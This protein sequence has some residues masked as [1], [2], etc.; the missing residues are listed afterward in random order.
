MSEQELKDV[1]RL[2]VST[3]KRLCYEDP[4]NDMY[5]SICFGRL[6]NRV[7][8][9]GRVGVGDQGDVGFARGRGV[10][11]DGVEASQSGR[12]LGQARR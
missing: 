10:G 6:S 1:S 12:S 11:L 3:A 5:K 8:S 4:N 9:R 7:F 2:K